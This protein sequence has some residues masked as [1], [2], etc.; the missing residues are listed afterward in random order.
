MVIDCLKSGLIKAWRQKKL[1]FMFY[2]FN[3]LFAYLLF[4]PVFYRFKA[5]VNSST[6]TAE[7]AGRLDMGFLFEFLHYEGDGLF[8]HVLVPILIYFLISFFLSAGALMVFASHNSSFGDAFWRGGARYFGRFFRLYL[9]SLVILAIL[10]FIPWGLFSMLQK[11]IWGPDF[12]QVVLVWGFVI[13]M[14]TTV[15]VLFVYAVVVDYARIHTVLDNRKKMRFA[16][17]RGFLFAFGNAGQTFFLAFLLV[18]IGLVWL[19]VYNIISGLLTSSSALVIAFLVLSQQIYILV[20][21]YFTLSRY[22]AEMDLYDNLSF[23][24]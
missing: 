9:W 2:V 1:I 22:A 12:S 3:L 18:I 10:L 7:L 17:Y 23:N 8:A 4:A 6:V 14:I 21:M 15:I 16:I 24:V 20:R 19:V 13:K 5:F 11:A